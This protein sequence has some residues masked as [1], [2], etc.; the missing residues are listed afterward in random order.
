MH[1]HPRFELGGDPV[2]S[3]EFCPAALRTLLELVA[4]EHPVA[5]GALVGDPLLAQAI[6]K[7]R[8]VPVATIDAASGHVWLQ[9]FSADKCRRWGSLFRSVAGW[10]EGGRR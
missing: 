2:A 7:G 5:I 4:V 3:F 9:V 10:P 8:V 6:E 1:P